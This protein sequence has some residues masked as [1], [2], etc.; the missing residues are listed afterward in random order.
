MKIWA[1]VK[2]FYKIILKKIFTGVGLAL[3]P[4]VPRAK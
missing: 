3:V 1:P 2:V 4:P